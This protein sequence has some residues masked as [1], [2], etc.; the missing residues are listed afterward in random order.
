MSRGKSRKEIKEKVIQL[1][2]TNQ[3]KAFTISD[4]AQALGERPRVIWDIID[5]LRKKVPDSLEITKVNRRNVIVFKGIPKKEE[6]VP[7]QN[8]E[9]S[10]SD[11]DIKMLEQEYLED[12]KRE[13]SDYASKLLQ[14][15]EEIELYEQ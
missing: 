10:I 7:E 2:V 9:E 8:L 6:E 11:I 4:I 12:I 14:I 3:G 5:W 1:L 15:L 13:K